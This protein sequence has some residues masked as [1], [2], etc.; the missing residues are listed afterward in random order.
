MRRFTRYATLALALLLVAVAL[1]ALPALAAPASQSTAALAGTS[2]VLSS[3]EGQ[4]PIPGATITLEF[5]EEDDTVTGTDG[6][7]RYTLPVTVD[8]TS[9][10]FGAATGATTLMACP[11]AVTTQAA[12]FMEA[13]AATTEFVFRNNQLALFNDDSILATF[14]SVVQQLDGTSWQVLAYNNGREAVTSLLEGSEITASFDDVEGVSG[15]AG[16]ND[17][18]G[19]YLTSDGAILFGSLGTTMRFC[20]T[21]AGVMEQEQE[22]LAALQSATR[23]TIEGGT[24]EMRDRSDAI[25]VI[26]ERV[27]DVIVPEPEPG[28]PT[29]RVTAA[30]GVNI[31]SGPGMNFPSFGIAP[32]GTE[33]EIIGRSADGR[34]WVVEAPSVPG[35]SAWVSADFV[36]VTDA[37]DVPIIASPPP[38][39]VIVPTP[40]PTP[41]PTPTPIP[42]ATATPAPQMNFSADRT[43]INQGDCTTIRW[44]VEHVQGVWVFQE[45]RHYRNYPRVGQGSEQVCP[46]TTTTYEMRVLQRNGAVSTQRV[47]VNVTPAAPQNPLNGTSWEVVNFNNGRGGLVTALGG[48]TLTARF[49]SDQINGN[50]GCNTFTGSY[51]VS[52]SS[53]WIGALAGGMMFCADVEGTMEQETEYLDALQS[54]SSFRISGNRLELLRWDGSIAVLFNRQ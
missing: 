51:S 16:C 3:L 2:W 43:T 14:V 1:V 27:F 13:L 30:R 40:V 46:P 15:N 19:T 28:V 39:I 26:M 8:G 48:T 11:E 6:C 36:A 50:G 18:F 37:D 32:F 12:D 42:A 38:P 5:S 53:I 17:Y 29:G 7:N 45:G 31:R 22:F 35:G 20:D 24:L 44:S 33:G 52:G 10:R 25:A 47:T 34:W 21:P 54:A 4:L 23:F 41:W 49:E 9:I